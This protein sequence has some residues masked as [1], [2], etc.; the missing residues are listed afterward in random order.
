M[1]NSYKNEIGIEFHDEHYLKKT[2]LCR[3]YPIIL[4]HRFTEVRKT[5]IPTHRQQCKQNVIGRRG[6][7]FKQR[8]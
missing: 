2:T 3:T 5:F 6:K 1:V 7:V 4:I 8:I